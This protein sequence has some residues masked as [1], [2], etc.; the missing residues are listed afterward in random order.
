MAKAV[1]VFGVLL[2]RGVDWTCESC[3]QATSWAII[4]QEPEVPVLPFSR[5][6]GLRFP[7]S[8]SLFVLRCEN[9]G[10]L[11]LYDRAFLVEK[12]LSNER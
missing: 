10:H 6:D 7:G 4:E 9:C 12:G 11:R 8:Q 1:D 5:E 2:R 3:K